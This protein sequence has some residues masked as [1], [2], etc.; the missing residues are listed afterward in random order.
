MLSATILA[1]SLPAAAAQAQEAA[2]E[3]AS[4]AMQEVNNAGADTQDEIVVTGIRRAT[5]LQDAPINISAVTAETLASQRIDDVADLAAF[6]PGLTVIDSGPRSTNA[7]VLRGISAADTGTGGSQRNTAVGIYLG[8]VPLYLDF[9]LIDIDRVEVLLGP[10]GTLYGLGTLAGAVRYIPN[11]PNT[12]EWGGSAHLRYYDVAH[13]KNPGVQGDFS[14]NIPIVKDMIAF[15][16]A[17]GYYDDPGFIDYPFL[18]GT[19]GTSLPQPDFNNPA[20]VAANLYRGRDLNDE[21]TFTTRNQL[22]FKGDGITTTLSYA[23]QQTR[24]NGR[25]ANGAGVLG[26]GKYEAAQRVVEPTKRNANL[27]AAEVEIN[28]FDIAEL[29]SATA[30]T[31]QKIKSQGDVTDLLLDLDYDYELFPAFAGYTRADTDYRQLNQELRLVSSHGGPLSWVVGGFFNRFEQYTFSAETFPRL[32]EF[33]GV[34]RPDGLEYISFT[35]SKTKEY[36]AFGELTFQITDEWQITGGGRYFEY[37]ADITG[38]TDTP[39]TGGGRRRTPFP[40]I[41]FDPSRVRSGSTKDNGFVWKA[42]SSFEITDD[43]LIYGTASKGYRIGGVNRVAPCLQPLPAGQNVCAL[44]NELGFG[45]DKTFNKEIGIRASLFDRAIQGTIAVFHINWD[46]VQVPSQTLNGAVGIT[47][48]AAKARSQGVETSFTAKFDQFVL[49]GNYAYNDA[50]LTADAPLLIDGEADAF[51]GDRLPG[52]TKHSGAITGTYTLPLTNDAELQAS[53]TTV[54]VG[55]IYSKTGLRGFGEKIPDYSVSRASLTYSKDGWEAT[56][57]ANNIFDRYA[58]NT[59]GNTFNDI[60]TN[61]GVVKRYYSRGV[62]TP[63]V[64]GVEFRKRF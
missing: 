9:K 37:E 47:A 34:F 12:T 56:A 36:A 60:G 50:K 51:D 31:E 43:L 23:Y 2:T 41:Q 21:Q 10:Q 46:D 30:Y 55:S 26:T 13:S 64:M 44:P 1:G 25:Q 5:T 62:I 48:N 11:R 29:V 6:T 4:A 40:L 57:F 28:L 22:L 33:L 17:T 15:R 39:L 42:N 52:S 3:I 63:R 54:Y 35:D 27:L 18:V 24:S 32:P 19:I 59:I 58:V 20:A 53:W 49:A 14:L 16:T 38:G 45:P 8:E 61:D 7:I